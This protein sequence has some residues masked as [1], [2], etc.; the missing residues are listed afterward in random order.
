MTATPVADPYAPYHLDAMP[1]GFAPLVRLVADARAAAAWLRSAAGGS[2]RGRRF[3]VARG[4]DP[5]RWVDFRL[6][7]VKRYRGSAGIADLEAAADPRH[8]EMTVVSDAPVRQWGHRDYRLTWLLAPGLED[9][10]CIL[11]EKL[12]PGALE[13]LAGDRD[14]AVCRPITSHPPE[15]DDVFFN[16][17]YFRMPGRG[18]D[19]TLVTCTDKELARLGH[20]PVWLPDPV[21]E[22]LFPSQ[23]GGGR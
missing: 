14:V 5:D 15:A 23:P 17:G 12:E 10:F 19:G 3:W 22:L 13:I 2:P 11:G 16:F 18:P 20:D 7:A 6:D 1:A 4:R 21:L 8:P 9:R